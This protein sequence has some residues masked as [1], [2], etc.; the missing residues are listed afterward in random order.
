[1][2][3]EERQKGPINH[4][5]VT[6]KLQLEPFALS[7]IQIGKAIS[8]PGTITGGAV[9]KTKDFPRWTT[10]W[11]HL[12]ISCPPVGGPADRETAGV[13]WEA[14]LG[15]CRGKWEHEME[16]QLTWEKVDDKPQYPLLSCTSFPAL[17]GGCSELRGLDQ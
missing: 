17:K 1:M 9:I 6:Q 12:T 16:V 4:N 7:K 15:I 10:R 13:E 8:I 5:V 11:T 2:Q 14:R 3:S